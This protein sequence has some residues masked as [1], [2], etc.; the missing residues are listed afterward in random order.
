MCAP[1]AKFNILEPSDFWFCEYLRL[2][3]ALNFSDRFLSA[4]LVMKFASAILL[5]AIATAIAAAP[6][7][8]E[9]GEAIAEE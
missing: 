5:A 1:A 3:R 6:V 9:K 7:E 4:H 2:I 8:V